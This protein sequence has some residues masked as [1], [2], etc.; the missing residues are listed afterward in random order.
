[1][2]QEVV[3]PAEPE[4][5]VWLCALLATGQADLYGQDQ[6]DLALFPTLTRT[7]M[8]KGQQLR[9]RAPGTN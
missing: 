7:W 5:I 1:V 9:V 2:R 3:D 4:A 6:A 8:K